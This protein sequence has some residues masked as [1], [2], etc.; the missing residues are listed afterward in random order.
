MPNTDTQPGSVINLHALEAIKF[1][2]LVKEEKFDV[3]RLYLNTGEKI[4]PH[5]ANGPITVQCVSGACTFLVENEPHE[6]VGGSWLYLQGSV[7]HALEAKQE[8]VLLVTRIL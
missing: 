6:L 2:I 1:T 3:I 5:K 8:C 4:A 7:M